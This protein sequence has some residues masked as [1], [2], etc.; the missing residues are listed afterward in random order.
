LGENLAIGVGDASEWGGMQPPKNEKRR[1]ACGKETKCFELVGGPVER[2]K[3]FSGLV[4]SKKVL[5]TPRV[6]K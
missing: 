1:D 4:D 5:V 6:L 2:G 3:H